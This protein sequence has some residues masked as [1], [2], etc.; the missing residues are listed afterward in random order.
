M[1]GT[2]LDL[3]RS[4]ILAFRRSAGDA[5][6]VEAESLPLPGTGGRIAVRWDD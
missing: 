1:T 5:V 6:A 3:T 2:Q 4:Q